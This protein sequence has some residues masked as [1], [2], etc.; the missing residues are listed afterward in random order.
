MSNKQGKRYSIDRGE[1]VPGELTST[2]HEE[3]RRLRR[4]NLEQ[5]KTIEVLKKSTAFFAR[6]S[7]R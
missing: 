2:E 7:D 5:Q 3:L 1:G 4:Q 6:E